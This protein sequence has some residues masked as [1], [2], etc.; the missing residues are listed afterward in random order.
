MVFHH[1]GQASLELPASSDPPTSDSPSARITGV[2]H[3]IG[4]NFF[5]PNRMLGYQVTDSKVEQQDNFLKRMSGMI[6][7]YAAIIQLRWPYGNLQEVSEKLTINNERLHHI[8]CVFL[9]REILTFFQ[10]ASL[11][12]G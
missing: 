3:H 5:F 6:R 8:P 2:S 11:V 7:L 1:V 4:P 12:K 10:K 9:P